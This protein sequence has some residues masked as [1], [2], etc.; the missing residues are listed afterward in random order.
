[1]FNFSVGEYGIFGHVGKG[2][3][4]KDVTFENVTYKADYLSALLGATVRG[5]TISNLK[6]TVSGYTIGE[7][8]HAQGFLASRY[9]QESTIKDVKIDARNCV[10]FTVL[11]WTVKGNTFTGVDVKVKSYTVLG[12]NDDAR[13]D[14]TKITALDGVTVTATTATAE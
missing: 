12:Y 2:A 1:M 9:L 7:F 13:N 14:T 11:G 10:V 5:A 8:P 6:L 3:L 4:I